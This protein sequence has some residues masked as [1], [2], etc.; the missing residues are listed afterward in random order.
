MTTLRH[1]LARVLNPLILS[2][3]CSQPGSR[4]V[5]AA[6]VPFIPVGCA[7]PVLINAQRVERIPRGRTRSWRRASLPGVQATAPAGFTAHEL[8]DA[9]N[10]NV[11]VIS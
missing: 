1:V 5:A 6:V 4:L 2:C 11:V 7:S 8:R 10:Q 3:P 9:T